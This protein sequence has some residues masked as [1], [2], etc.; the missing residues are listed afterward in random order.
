MLNGGRK[1]EMGNT[2]SHALPAAAS[3][4]LGATDDLARKL[5][6]PARKAMTGRCALKVPVLGTAF[7][8][9]DKVHPHPSGSRRPKR[10]DPGIIATGDRRNP[11]TPEATR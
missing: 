3:R 6:H 11:V 4:I 7:E 5:N 1:A 10:A 9:H 8:T 2:H